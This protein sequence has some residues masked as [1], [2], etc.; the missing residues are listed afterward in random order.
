MSI[1]ALNNIT[2]GDSYCYLAFMKPCT[3]N[4]LPLFVVQQGNYNLFD[5]IIR[6]S[7]ISNKKV[8]TY[9]DIKNDKTITFPTLY[10]G[11]GTD[12]SE[13]IILPDSGEAEFNV[14][15]NARNGYWIQNIKLKKV[16]GE[17]KWKT[18]IVKQLNMTDKKKEPFEANDF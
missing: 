14:F 1:E 5:V 16:G 9:Q 11:F 3:S 4:T 17:W 15:I 13:E 2:G 6:I 18:N 12:K 8:H 10:A 7:N